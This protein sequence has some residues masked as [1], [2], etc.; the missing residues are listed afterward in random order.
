MLDDEIIEL[1]LIQ[2]YE[3]ARECENDTYLQAWNR[4]PPNEPREYFFAFLAK[5]IRHISLD[6]CK[7]RNRQKRSGTLV[8]LTG[9]L[10]QCIPDLRRNVEMA[11]EGKEFGRIVSEFLRTLPEQQ[12]K[13]FVRRYWFA[14]SVQEIA[15]TFDC[16]ENTVKSILFRVRK[17]MKNYLKSCISSCGNVCAG[18][19]GAC[20]FRGNSA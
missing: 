10:E 19:G 18:A 9:E 13:I 4:I 5:I 11:V 2:D 8:E 17:R 7:K 16:S 6:V 20:G 3:T 14:D 15:D 1:Y 12:R